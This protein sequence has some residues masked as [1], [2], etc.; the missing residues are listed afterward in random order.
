MVRMIICDDMEDVCFYYKMV[1]SKVS[2]FEVVGVAFNKKDAI[3]LCISEK[4]DIMLVDMQMDTE[5]SGIEII[6]EIK[7]HGIDTKIIVLTVH[8]DDDKIFEAY[9]LGIDDYF[10]KSLPDESLIDTIRDVSD[11]KHVLRPD[12]AQKVLSECARLKSDIKQTKERQR[13]LLHTVNVMRMLSNSEFEILKS[14]YDGMSVSGIAESR[15]V[16]ETTV[17]TH[18]GRVLKKFGCSNSKTLVNDLRKINAFAI[19]DEI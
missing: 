6:R 13:S 18:I 11:N 14:L 10:L 12:I 17:R 19:F 8:E 3:D 15:F 5:K 4:P 9:T 16:S 1:L 7:R 2:D